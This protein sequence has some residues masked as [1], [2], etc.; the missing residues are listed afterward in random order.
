MWM[1][2]AL[3]ARLIQL[4]SHATHRADLASDDVACATPVPGS[5][6]LDSPNN[7]HTNLKM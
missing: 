4:A 7:H 6:S 1:L 3:I 2:L 5:F